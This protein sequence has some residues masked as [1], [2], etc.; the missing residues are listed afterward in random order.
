MHLFLLQSS[1]LRAPRDCFSGSYGALSHTWAFIKSLILKDK[2]EYLYKDSL[3]YSKMLDMRGE[4]IDNAT[5][6]SKQHSSEVLQQ[7]KLKEV[8]E[9]L[10][11]PSEVCRMRIKQHSNT[12]TPLFNNLSA[13]PSRTLD[14]PG[15]TLDG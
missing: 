15:K 11:K 7:G 13:M 1:P 5:P 4:A 10:D 3:I 6:R 12:A 9:V 14:K 8:Q 2:C